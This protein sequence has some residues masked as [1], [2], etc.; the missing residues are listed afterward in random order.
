MSVDRGYLNLVSHLNRHSTNLPLNTILGSVAHHLAYVQPSATPLAAIVISSPLFH[1]S[2]YAD[3]DGLLTAFRHA[4][5]L[6]IKVVYDEPSGLFSRGLTTRVA[7]W[8]AEVLKGFQGGHSVLR[9]ACCAGLLHG[10][11]DREA[12]LKIKENFAG[13]SVEEELIIALA[14]VVEYASADPWEAE[15]RLT[16]QREEGEYAPNYLMCIPSQRRLLL[17]ALPATLVIASRSLPLVTPHRLGALPLLGFCRVLQS[18]FT[19]AFQNGTFIQELQPSAV[20]T[21]AGKLSVAT[22]SQFSGNVGEVSKGLLFAHMATLSAMYAQVISLLADGRPLDAWTAISELMRALVQLATAA[23]D[24]WARHP[25]ASIDDEETFSPETKEL[26]VKVWAILK[27]LLFTCIRLL[28]QV[29][30]VVLFVSPPPSPLISLPVPHGLSN[31]WSPSPFEMARTALKTLSHLSFILPRFG[32]VSSTASSALPE[33]L[34]AFYTALDVLSTSPDQSRLLVRTLKQEVYSMG[35]K[36]LPG[37]LVKAKEAYAL[38]CVEQL[39]P[40]LDDRTMREDVWPMCEP[41]LNDSPHRETYESAHSVMLAMFS[42]HAKK[43]RAGDASTIVAAPLP[44]TAATPLDAPG[45][46]SGIDSKSS[47]IAEEAQLPFAEQVVPAYAKCLIDNSHPDKLNTAQLRMAYGALVSCASVFGSSQHKLATSSDGNRGAEARTPEGDAYA[48]FCVEL[49]LD[50]INTYA[51]GALTEQENEHR[52]KLL[53]T[54]V[55]TVPSVSLRLLPRL[56]AAIL[57]LL[58]SPAASKSYSPDAA[59]DKDRSWGQKDG[60]KDIIK[61]FFEELLN[62]GDEEKEHALWWWGEHKERLADGVEGQPRE[63]DI[64]SADS[65][66]EP[67]I[68]AQTVGKGKARQIAARL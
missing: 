14:E 59:A 50:A 66:K 36:A 2:S 5:H 52:Q 37:G 63:M 47:G 16:A 24:G 22:D 26:A 54:L 28:Q 33:L 60:R 7:E 48:W 45:L 32:G 55:S 25:F 53:L 39:V 20:I 10:L 12:D 34:K 38:A 6:K 3:L 27:T 41:H 18:A 64:G 40:V 35:Q 17:D 58:E 31:T 65:D 8:V 29:L 19:Q 4:V 43:R 9:L 30:N 11:A 62:V 57:K 51:A 42:A 44:I 56:L 21:E 15:F 13:R 23:E 68:F 46:S 49:L 67:E 61:A 1:T